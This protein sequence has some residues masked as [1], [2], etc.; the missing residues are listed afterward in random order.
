M[1][2]RA[3]PGLCEYQEVGERGAAPWCTLPA[4]AEADPFS[5][6][7]AA[8]TAPGRTRNHAAD[9]TR[10]LVPH[11]VGAFCGQSVS[12]VWKSRAGEY[13]YGML[14]VSHVCESVCAS[15]RGLI[16]AV[17]WMCVVCVCA[18]VVFVFGVLVHS[19]Q[20]PRIKAI[21]KAHDFVTISS[22]LQ[23]APMHG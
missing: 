8:H 20:V 10:V 18:C 3:R 14:H 13:D 1:D 6:R 16:A 5:D 17:Y 15:S 4:H 11:R 21:R 9:A 23:E 7:L 12:R 19:R 2:P 22:K